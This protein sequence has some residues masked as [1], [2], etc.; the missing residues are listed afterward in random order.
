MQHI[1]IIVMLSC[2]Q[3]VID[4]HDL[5]VNNGVLQNNSSEM[6]CTS[7]HLH[8]HTRMTNYYDIQQQAQQQYQQ[9]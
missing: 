8:T 9:F 6:T 7:A 4:L 1:N 5:N 2:M 3:H